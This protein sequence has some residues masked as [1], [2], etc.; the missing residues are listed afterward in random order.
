MSLVSRRLSIGDVG[1]AN[2]GVI[3]SMI[4]LSLVVLTGYSG[5]IS[6]AQLTFVGIGAS[7][8][9]KVGGGSSYLGVLAAVGFGAVAG[10]LVALPALRLRGLYLA[11][12]TLAFARA[13][14]AAFFNNNK[15]FGQGGAVHV[16]R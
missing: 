3:L 4:M 8:M 16:G 11:L 13:M 5:Q 9:G 1:I 14:D 10:A 12:T 15:V 2:K 6:L 7:A